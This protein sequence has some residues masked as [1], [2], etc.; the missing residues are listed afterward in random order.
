MHENREISCT[1]WSV[2]QDRSAKAINRRADRNEQEKSDCAVVR[3]P[4][5][6]VRAVCVKAPVRICAGGDQRW[7]SLPLQLGLSPGTGPA[8]RPDRRSLDNPLRSDQN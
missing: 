3:R 6:T 7:T 5:S 1:S 8:G 2:D 4:L